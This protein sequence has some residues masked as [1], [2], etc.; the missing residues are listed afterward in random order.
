MAGTGEGSG[1]TR[2][3]HEARRAP[4]VHPSARREGE[5][6]AESRAERT[7]PNSPAGRRQ[8]HKRQES[9]E[10]ASQVLLH[11]RRLPRSAR[12]RESIG[13]VQGCTA[14]HWPF[15]PGWRSCAEGAGPCWV[16]GPCE[17]WNGCRTKAPQSPG[18]VHPV[19][20]ASCTWRTGIPSPARLRPAVLRQIGI[21]LAPDTPGVPHP[22]I[23]SNPP[24]AGNGEP[25]F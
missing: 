18:F 2:A 22:H 10:L 20:A 21:K 8:N 5:R 17:T 4:G 23:C 24:V 25:G 16:P 7:R 3:A 14:V 6:G 19:L 12:W 9:P 13:P 15:P 11:P 1:R